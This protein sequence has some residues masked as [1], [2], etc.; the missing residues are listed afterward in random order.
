MG[1]GFPPPGGRRILVRFLSALSDSGLGG[2]LWGRLTFFLLRSFRLKLKLWLLRYPP[3][4]LALRLLRARFPCPA[5]ARRLQREIL[6]CGEKGGS[7][8]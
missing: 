2:S 6:K 1:L 5:F 4:T 3:S 7:G 8:L